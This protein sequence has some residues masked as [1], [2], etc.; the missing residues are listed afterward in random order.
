MTD[1]TSTHLKKT[2]GRFV[3]RP[4]VPDGDSFSGKMT[5]LEK[6][7]WMKEHNPR[8]KLIPYSTTYLLAVNEM[9]QKVRGT[10]RRPEVPEWFCGHVNPG[11]PWLEDDDGDRGSGDDN[12]GLS[13]GDGK[14]G[15]KNT[16]PWDQ[17]C[18][19]GMEPNTPGYMWCD[20]PEFFAVNGDSSFLSDFTMDVVYEGAEFPVSEED[21]DSGGGGDCSEPTSE[22]Q[23]PARSGEFALG[24]WGPGK[25]GAADVNISSA[26]M[27]GRSKLSWSYSSG[28]ETV[29]GWGTDNAIVCLG[30]YAEDQWYSGKMDHLR[31]GQTSKGLENVKCGYNGWTAGVLAKATKGKVCVCNSSTK[32]CSNWREFSV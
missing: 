16:Y 31:A 20:E 19:Y 5:A 32:E 13:L 12:F 3:V 2:V 1:Q 26:S 15:Q 22:T 7:A 8:A 28:G 6:I 17:C 30:L 11:W 25:I 18:E 21:E 24:G 4:R 27:S 23:M 9:N 14:E 10:L 29:N